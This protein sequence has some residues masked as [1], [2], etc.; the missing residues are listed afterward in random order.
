MSLTA[1][2]RDMFSNIKM[3]YF[4][5]FVRSHKLVRNRNLSPY[6][7]L[8]SWFRL[9]R[10]ADEFDEYIREL[11]NGKLDKAV[12]QEW[13]SS[14]LR[15]MKPNFYA[16]MFRIKRISSTSLDIY[17]L[18]GNGNQ[19]HKICSSA[20]AF[21]KDIKRYCEFWDKAHEF[22]NEH[23]VIN[24][25]DMSDAEVK[26]G[27]RDALMNKLIPEINRLEVLSNNPDS[28][29]CL[30]YYDLDSGDTEL[31]TPA[32]DSFLAQM[33]NDDCRNAFRAF[34]YSIFKGDNYG[35][36]VLWLH[37]V[38][39][40][41]KSRATTAIYEFLQQINPSIVTSL[42][43]TIAMDK[44][45]AGTY[46]GKRLAIAADTTDRSLVK[47]NLVKNL[48][49]ADIISNRG[50][51]KAKEDARIYSKIIVTSNQLP[52]VNVESPEQKSRMLLISL[53]PEYCVDAKNKWHNM[54]LGDWESMLQQELPDFISQSKEAYYSFIKDDGH[55]L[56]DYD[57]HNEA[58]DDTTYFVRRDLPKWWSECV[59][60]TNDVNDTIQVKDLAYDYLRFL[61]GTIYVKN[62]RYIALSFVTTFLRESQI[63]LHSLSNF[64]VLYITGYRFIKED[65]EERQTA[66]EVISELMREAT[67]E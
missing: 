47:N 4:N 41:G 56:R 20:D 32:W 34:V 40:S 14:L 27:F 7:Q 36:Q 2:N 44:F 66:K 30:A 67:N 63:P 60:K 16:A 42:E 51:G 54:N 43:A 29:Y 13:E 55:N 11:N 24:P 5:I 15:N 45:S 52:F 6:N 22:C 25:A 33:V 59:E 49:G 3:D 38:G 18:V 39:E 64:A 28:G 58:L 37:G 8:K 12:V 1:D 50:M 17:A 46:V 26:S 10:L 21:H 19:L 62:G 53:V 35:R 9:K 65:P 48:T 61:R 23:D 57:G 31:P